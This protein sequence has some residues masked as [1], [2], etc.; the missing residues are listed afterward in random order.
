MCWYF[1][2]IVSQ[3][4]LGSK[5]IQKWTLTDFQILEVYMNRLFSKFYNVIKLTILK[6]KM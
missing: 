3:L 1:P 4:K 6:L 5:A 2:H